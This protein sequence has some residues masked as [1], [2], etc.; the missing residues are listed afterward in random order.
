MKRL[1]P[2]LRVSF[3]RNFSAGFVLLALLA[4]PV[5]SSAANVSQLRGDAFGYSSFTGATNWDDG[6]VPSAGNDYFNA[7]YLLRTPADA[8]SYTF[9]GDSLT[10][11]GAG[12]A[13]GANNEA[14]MWK[15]SGTSAII[16]VNS[17]TING[18]Q[19]RH[20][21]GD[22]DTF[23]LAGNITIGANNANFATQGG[24]IIT[25]PIAGS[26]TIRVLDSG[27]SD[28][29]REIRLASGANTFTGDI[30]LYGN[31]SYRSRLRLADDANMNFVIGASGVNNSIFGTGTAY[32]DGDFFF[33]LL[34]AGTTYG[35]EWLIED[36][37]RPIYGDTFT[38]S[39]WT[40][41]GTDAWT[42]AA[43]GTLYTFW[44]STGI[45]RVPEPSS[46]ALL[47][48]GAVM[49]LALRRHRKA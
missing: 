48:G 31:D 41:V 42:T 32:L 18:G 36:V 25:A 10:I 40:P 46:I 44:E 7:T 19:L 16:T 14:L 22:A 24:M 2:K 12:L 9:Q 3:V 13:T 47:L 23:T 11:T 8:N 33:D 30:Q 20:G 15:G 6:M 35:D 29:R 27:S 34:G 28:G 1:E 45:L 49:L 43:N 21:Q 17:L 38:V 26:T 4:A 5:I 37:T 39:G